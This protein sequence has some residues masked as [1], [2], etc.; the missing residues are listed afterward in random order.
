MDREKI[1]KSTKIVL[2]VAIVLRV[3]ILGSV[4]LLGALIG[5][6]LSIDVMSLIQIAFGQ[7]AFSIVCPIIAFI[8]VSK[9][10]KIGG[11]LEIITGITFVLGGMSLNLFSLLILAFGILLILDGMKYYKAVS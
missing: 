3:V 9:E 8:L 2:I 1:I 7:I 6:E 10:N 4:F 11:I 5:S